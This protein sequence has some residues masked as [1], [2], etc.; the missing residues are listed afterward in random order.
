VGTPAV[1]ARELIP[2]G[3]VNTSECVGAWGV[4]RPAATIV[5]GRPS[6]RKIA[7]VGYWDA[8]YEKRK[9]EQVPDLQGRAPASVPD[10][11]M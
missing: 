6:A 5:R 9:I 1:G 10:A 4:Q 8:H 7:K 11:S 3:V 2:N